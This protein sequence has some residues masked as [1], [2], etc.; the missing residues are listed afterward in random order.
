MRSHDQRHA[1][2]QADRNG[3]GT[4]RRRNAKPIQLRKRQAA[5]DRHNAGEGDGR[6]IPDGAIQQGNDQHHRVRKNHHYGTN[7]VGG[8]IVG[9]RLIKIVAGTDTVFLP[10]YQDKIA[11]V[12]LPT[13]GPDFFITDNMSGCALF[14]GAGPHGDLVVFH[15]NS[16]TGSDQKTMDENAPSFQSRKALKEIDDQMKFAVPHHSTLRLV[17]SLT[18][19]TYL[20]NVDQLTGTG[21]DF[22]GGT[23][24][25]GW[26]TGTTFLFRLLATDL[27]L[28]APLPAELTA[29]WR[30]AGLSPAEREAALDASGAAHD[31]LHLLNPR[32]AAVHD[33]GPRLPEE[34]VLAMGTDFR[35][36][37]FSSTVRLESYSRWLA[38]EDLRPSSGVRSNR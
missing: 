21:K 32:L 35:N 38:G 27:R 7:V 1:P 5:G 18:K 24:I 19:P 37:G 31:F 4:G 36:W 16:Q 8:N 12:R 15:A 9:T 17:C 25:A 2:H 10:Y 26:R 14:I 3:Q 28:R 30:I 6:K 20:A 34:C 13:A 11:S 33:S 22:L 29:P 23:T